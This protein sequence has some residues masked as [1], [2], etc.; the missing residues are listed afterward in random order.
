MSKIGIFFGGKDN[1]STAKVARK[2]QELLGADTTVHNVGSA[3]KHDVEKY[4]FLVLGTA[5]WGIGE[6]HSDWERFIDKMIESDLA[7]KK[8]ALFGLGDQKMYPESF[9]DGMG[10][11]FCRLP[12]KENVIGYTSI[13]GYNF[14]YSTAEKDEKF[15]GLAIDDDTQPEF[16]DK[17]I[18]DW[19]KQI[20]K[21]AGL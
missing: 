2:I 11:I 6:M 7:T 1:G 10:T 21:E 5:A 12:H 9:V 3:A 8:I 13:R 17:R 18:K 15:V 19:V 4:D 16:T 14:Y 20:K